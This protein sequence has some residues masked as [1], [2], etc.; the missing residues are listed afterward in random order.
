M[1]KFW[2]ADFLIE[3]FL[4]WMLALCVCTAMIATP[5]NGKQRHSRAHF[6]SIFLWSLGCH[7]QLDDNYRNPN[8]NERDHLVGRLT[9][10]PDNGPNVPFCSKSQ[11]WQKYVELNCSVRI[12]TPASMQL[13]AAHITHAAHKTQA[14]IILYMEHTNLP[15][16]PPWIIFV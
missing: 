15:R 9:S 16:R 12:A 4:Y 1:F 7:C 3:H 13:N 6:C 11:L 10:C 14:K 5:S 8:N 2:N